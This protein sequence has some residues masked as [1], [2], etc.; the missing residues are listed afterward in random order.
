MS[1]MTLRVTAAATPRPPKWT[2]L[3]AELRQRARSRDELRTLADRNISDVGLTRA[4]TDYE[5]DK[6]FFHS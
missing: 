1:L 6:L 4:E 3:L 5:A 2:K